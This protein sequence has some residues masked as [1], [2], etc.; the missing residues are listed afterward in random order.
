MAKS[1]IYRTEKGQA[2]LRFIPGS[3]KVT[4]S[5]EGSRTVE[6]PG[7]RFHTLPVSIELSFRRQAFE[8]F[9]GVLDGYGNFPFEEVL[10]QQRVSPEAADSDCQNGQN[11]RPGPNGVD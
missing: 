7:G 6:M 11:G 8:E 1:I 3:E 10:R 4:L 2:A 5:V 9:L